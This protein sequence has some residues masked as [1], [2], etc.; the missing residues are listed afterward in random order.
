MIDI[1]AASP[2][3]K[4]EALDVSRE[5]LKSIEESEVTLSNIALKA[6]RLA[7]LLDDSD[8]LNIFEYEV[9]GYPSSK[10]GIPKEVWKLAII[11]KRTF[12][13]KR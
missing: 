5:I 4:R 1:A 8:Y 2:E 9:N 10:N 3:I 11:A 7:R 13:G 6:I 12:Q